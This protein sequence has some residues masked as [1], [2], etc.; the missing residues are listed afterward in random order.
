M[1]VAEICWAY[2]WTS[3]KN[4]AVLELRSQSGWIKGSPNCDRKKLPYSQRISFL[5]QDVAAF[6]RKRSL[7][8]SRPPHLTC[9][10]LELKSKLLSIYYCTTSCKCS[11]FTK[12][13]SN[14]RVSDFFGITFT[15]EGW[16]S[17]RASFHTLEFSD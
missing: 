13:T 8:T 10:F 6:Q 5:Q 2:W 11:C 9:L 3:S 16:E 12:K 1:V 14:T 15:E 17:K 4:Q 7:R